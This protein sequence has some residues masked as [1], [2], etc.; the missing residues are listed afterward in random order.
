MLLGEQAK[1]EAALAEASPRTQRG[2]GG[3]QGAKSLAFIFMC[4]YL[5]KEGWRERER[6]L[7][8][9]QLENEEGAC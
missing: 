4:I 9:R 1:R 7:L 8:T 6:R 5:E 2:A 3:G